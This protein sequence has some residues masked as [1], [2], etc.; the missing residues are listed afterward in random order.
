MLIY[1]AAYNIL[2]VYLENRYLNAADTDFVDLV[3]TDI[4][5]Y[6]KTATPDRFV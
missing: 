1:V 2:A 6:Q 4:G 5:N 3:T